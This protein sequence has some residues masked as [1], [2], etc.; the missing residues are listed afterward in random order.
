[1]NPV[2]A[3][4]KR[5]EE[6]QIARFLQA[7]KE[8]GIAPAS[9]VY[10][11]V[12]DTAVAVPDLNRDREVLVS[13]IIPSKDHPEN[14]RRCT[15]SLLQTVHPERDGLRYEIIV[16]DNGSS[17]E[18]RSK[19]NEIL[20]N[21]S[22]SEAA[23]RCRCFYR[24]EPF[25]F[26]RMC[27]R[28]AKEAQ[29]E[30]LLFL[31]DD[32]RA[33]RPGWLSRMVSCA[34][35]PQ[36]GCVGAK[37]LYPEGM[38]RKTPLIQHCGV[39]NTRMGPVHKLAR[40]PDSYGYF[41][42][43]NHGVRRVIAVTGACLLI[44]RVIFREIGGFS[45]ELPVAFNDVDLCYTLYEK[46]YDNLCC[47]DAPLMHYESF[48]RGDDSEDISKMVR[49]SREYG[50]LTSRHKGLI[51]RDP[52]YPEGFEE[53]IRVAPEA[54]AE[55]ETPPY[56]LARAKKCAVNGFMRRV[57]MDAC[58][59]AGVECAGNMRRYV[60]EDEVRSA[61]NA[62]KLS[63][64]EADMLWDD[65][66]IRGYSFVIGSDNA[67]YTKRLLLQ[68]MIAEGDTYVPDEGSLCAFSLRETYRPEIREQTSGLTNVA[69]C[70]FTARIPKEALTPGV[71][72]IG[73]MQLRKYSRETLYNWGSTVLV[74]E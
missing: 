48:S 10:P 30:L 13:I 25:S 62:G 12:E 58:V 8:A 21:A 1:M 22:T 65:Y 54:R 19:V 72:R 2:Y 23:P 61:L 16:V 71:W 47:N 46:G 36:V 29:G 5:L 20:I 14:I 63:Q 50:I 64:A 56:L 31:N 18:N 57:R 39:V 34:M 3:F 43:Y 17:P 53:G 32:T 28:G 9:S 41:L 49:L 51:A 4:R 27:N 45:E 52:F 38:R 70:G 24:E 74:A 7:E 26:S 33:I 15:E 59:R 6:K 60:R 69:F 40:M 66:W 68:K 73:V 55:K 35:M 67:L 44:R 11:V 37:L 42:D